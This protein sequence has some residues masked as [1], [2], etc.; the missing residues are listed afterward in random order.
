MQK[1]CFTIRALKAHELKMLL[2]AASILP[3]GAGL[4]LLGLFLPLPEGVELSILG[5]F[6]PS[7][8]N[9]EICKIIL[10]CVPGQYST[11]STSPIPTS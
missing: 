11:G 1:L 6:F 8:I 2:V 3:E 9:A 5:F 10:K 7:V 4:S